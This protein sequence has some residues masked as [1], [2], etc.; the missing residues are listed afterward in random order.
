M[1]RFGV[2]IPQAGSLASPSF[3]RQFCT[4]AE[5]LGFTTLWAVDHLVAPIRTDSKYPLGRR[6][7]ALADGEVAAV[8]SPNYE[9]VSTLAWVCG[10]TTRVQLG[11]SVAVLSIRN[12]LTMAR[13]IATIDALSGG[14]VVFGV[15][16]GWLKEEAEALA[17]P[18]SNR[19]QR[20]EEA[21]RLMRALW[22]APEGPFQFQG[23]YFDVPPI[24]PE[25]RP[26]QRPIPIYVGGHS[27]KAL[28]RAG[29]LG[30]VGADCLADELPYN[31]RPVGPR[32]RRLPSGWCNPP[33]SSGGGGR[34]HRGSRAPRVPRRGAT[35]R[36]VRELAEPRQA[37]DRLG[38][39]V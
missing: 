27:A 4:R 29:R 20:L 38:V 13:Q 8:L 11:T 7:A 34:P 35:R 32:G 12:A 9:M 2:S 10:F 28:D 31:T 24:D 3:A 18:W 36:G 39:S 22:S 1:L 25:P 6:P 5:E 26:V 17:M 30:D 19:G 33:S 15:G 23:E 16:V 21:I 14:R 37:F